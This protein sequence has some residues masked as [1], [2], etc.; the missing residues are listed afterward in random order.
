MLLSMKLFFYS[1]MNWYFA[2]N[3]RKY[4]F[5]KIIFFQTKF[6]ML[7]WSLWFCDTIFINILEIVH[8]IRRDRKLWPANVHFFSDPWKRVPSNIDIM[9][10]YVKLKKQKDNKKTYIENLR[11]AKFISVPFKK[12]IEEITFKI[13]GTC[14]RHTLVSIYPH[15]KELTKNQ[16]IIW[17]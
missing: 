2:S 17:F 9:K 10:S 5:L 3:S 8:S 15:W 7:L 1:E 16:E 12:F 13:V 14:L 11:C 6:Y 4:D